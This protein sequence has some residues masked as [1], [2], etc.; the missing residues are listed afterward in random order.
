MQE[1]KLKQLSKEK[2]VEKMKGTKFLIGLF[3]PII[4]LLAFFIIRDYI[5]T[6]EM[7]VP[8]LIITICS[9]GGMFTLFPE[10]KKMKEEL[11]R[12]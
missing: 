3:I 8:T 10:L 9:I 11:K 1:D 5:K 7:D 12:R 2:L 6:D 4:I